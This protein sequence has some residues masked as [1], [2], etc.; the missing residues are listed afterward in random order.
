[1]LC[2]LG[3]TFGRTQ[4]W[5]QDPGSFCATDWDKLQ[6]SGIKVFHPSFGRNPVEPFTDA[7]QYFCAW[8]G[9]I[10]SN[11]ERFYRVDGR[12]DLPAQSLSD[13][14]G[15]I[16]GAQSAYHLRS[17]EDVD[18]FYRL[19]QRVCQLTYNTMTAIGSGCTERVDGGLSAYGLAVVARM[20][21][22]GMVVDVSHCGDRTTLDA[23]EGSGG[24][25]LVTH[26]N[27][28][29]LVPGHPRGKT[30]EAIRALARRGGVIG[31]TTLRN[32]VCDHEPTTLEH[33]LDQCSHV[34]DLVGPQH[35]GIGTDTDLDGWDATDPGVRARVVASMGPQY[36]FRERLDIDGLDHPRKFFNMAEGLLRRGFCAADVA[37]VL[38]NNFARVLRQVWK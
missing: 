18:L 13:K 4:A 5:L 26:A 32:F 15:L 6:S 9:F 1:M 31:L 37:G 34:A 10:A 3:F 11:S 28:R 29:E 14:V 19:G 17:I 21:A 25:V 38:G 24:P 12:D 27:C 7:L 8:N 16:L 35:L 22:V 33:W 2:P 23:I 20:D 30:D 36:R